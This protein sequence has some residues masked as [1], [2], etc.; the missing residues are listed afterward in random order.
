[1]IR[2][3]VALT[4]PF[5]TA[6]SLAHSLPGE[7]SEAKTYR[8]PLQFPPF[9]HDML[10]AKQEHTDSIIHDSHHLAGIFEFH[11][12]IVVHN[13]SCRKFGPMLALTHYSQPFP[14]LA[15]KA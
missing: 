12:G 5:S 1:V 3:S 10:V 13:N 2:I 6:I 15:C 8:M 7:S 4:S 14:L 9:A 11:E